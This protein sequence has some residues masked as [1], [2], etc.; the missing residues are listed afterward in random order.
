[1]TDLRYAIRGLARTPSFAIVAIVS[2]ALGIGANVTIYTIANAFLDQ[3]IAGARDVDRLVRIY[4]GDHSPLQYADLVRVR[5]QRAA[6]SDVAGERMMGV[7][8]ANG[9][10][11]ERAMA[12]LTTDGYFRMLGV[13]PELGRFFGAVDSAESAP[14][15][16]V[17]HAFWQNRLN[18]DSLAIGRALRINDRSFTVIGVA[19]AEFASSIFL[20]RADLWFAPSAAKLLL[21]MPFDRWGGSLYVTARLAPGATAAIASATLTTVATR[22]VAED[23]SGHERFT[24]RLDHARGIQAE[25]RPATIA[26]SS[27]MMAVVVLVLLIACANVANLLLAR[28][29]ARRREI[30][31]RTALGAGRARLVRQLLVES[32]LVATSG[33]ALGLLIAMW[34]AELLRNFAIARSPEPIA[35]E[36]SPDAR[37][38]V[39]AVGVSV[40]SAIAFGLVPALRATSVEILP[41]LRE[42]APQSTGRSRLRR[43]LI[44][45][46]MAL[47]TLLLACATLFLRSLANARVIDPGFDARGIYDISLDVSSRNL[48]RERTIAFYEALR[49]RAAA[50]PGARFATVAAIVPLGGSNMQIGSWVEGRDATGGSRPSF[51]PYF[52]VV[53]QQYFETLGI[54]VVAGRVFT[55]QDRAGAPG[56]IVINAHM[57]THLWPGDNALGKRISFE[58][59]T[60]PWLTVVGVVRDTKY[61][62]LGEKTPDFV[63]LPFAQNSRA[64]MVLQVRADR[65]GGVAAATLRDLVHEADPLLPP[66]TIASLEEDMRIVLLPAQLAAGLLGAFGLL[67]LLIASVG[68]YGVASYEV[69][70]RTR[71][72]GIRSALGATARDL[73]T[74]VVSQAMRVVV[75][76]AVV[77]LV[78][79]LGAARLLTTQLY[80]VGATDPLAF[81]AMPVVLGLVAMLATWIPARRAT[82]VD[83]VEALRAE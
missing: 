2:L 65:T 78:L 33:G 42:D 37:V 18:G 25:L 29:T 15:V 35:L 56:V 14:A 38:L 40:V 57:A 74:L 62:S 45:A 71:E 55:P 50:L 77:G 7:A 41:V 72:L 1:M 60:G 61:N 21:G 8:V 49:N 34:A 22:L 17:S 20:W 9:A 70:Q 68:I 76:G 32:I 3:P 58:G 4:R 54:P 81:V 51:A 46:Q 19:P 13:H 12:S 59:P 26:A 48:D 64:E 67:A 10:G 75:I 63:F 73:V 80:G 39:F 30:S 43:T 27:F 79:A 28:A 36:V 11:T 82:R 44:G 16:V 47:C 31:V 83:P 24:L 6:F 66:L 53:G 69:A 23:P 5:D 52:N